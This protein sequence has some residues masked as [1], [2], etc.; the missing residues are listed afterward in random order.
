MD[1]CAVA[2]QVDQRLEIPVG[3]PIEHREALRPAVAILDEA[4]LAQSARVCWDPH[5][6]AWTILDVARRNRARGGA[7]VAVARRADAA[8]GQVALLDTS[9]SVRWVATLSSVSCASVTS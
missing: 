7:Q 4:A 1:L 2:N 3:E 9:S 8:G 6:E 5:D